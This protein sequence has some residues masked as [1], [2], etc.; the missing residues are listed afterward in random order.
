L[1]ESLIKEKPRTLDRVSAALAETERVIEKTRRDAVELLR[2]RGVIDRAALAAWVSGARDACWRITN[3]VERET[4]FVI[5][6]ALP[7]VHDESAELTREPRQ[8]VIRTRPGSAGASRILQRV[9]LPIDLSSEHVKAELRDGALVIEA[10][11]LPNE[12]F[13]A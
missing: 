8:L 10:P 1:P 5:T 6:I 9:D 3:I 12:P 7:G 13:T 4:A 2:A 11:K